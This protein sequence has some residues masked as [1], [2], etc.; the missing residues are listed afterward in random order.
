MLHNSICTEESPA[1]L[2][3]NG[4]VW[5]V[6]CLR[7]GQ[8]E[9]LVTNISCNSGLTHSRGKCPTGGC[10]GSRGY[11]SGYPVGYW[12]SPSTADSVAGAA[13]HLPM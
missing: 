11:H 5:R 9:P 7:A 3:C 13:A 2:S 6:E 12:G 8:V 10:E 1:R 4:Q